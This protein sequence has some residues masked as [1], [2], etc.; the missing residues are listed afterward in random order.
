MIPYNF[1]GLVGN[2]LSNF[3]IINDYNLACQSD[4]DDDKINTTRWNEII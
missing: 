2:C 3:K 1:L 4:Q